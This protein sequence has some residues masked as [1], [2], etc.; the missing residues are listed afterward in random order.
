MA[1][2]CFLLPVYASRCA[3]CVAYHEWHPFCVA[4][5]IIYLLLQGHCAD[6][7]SYMHVSLVPWLLHVLAGGKCLHFVL[8]AVCLVENRPSG[9]TITASDR[10]VLLGLG[11]LGRC[12][13][14]CCDCLTFRLVQILDGA[15]RQVIAEGLPLW[16]CGTSSPNSG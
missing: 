1:G 11:F 6:Y 5:Q 2:Q 8:G 15:S 3:V 9:N 13:T 10:V 7:L 12:N 14:R 4:T 16:V